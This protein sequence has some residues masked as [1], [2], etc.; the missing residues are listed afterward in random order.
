MDPFMDNNVL[1]PIIDKLTLSQIEQNDVK[2]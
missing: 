2:S 1:K